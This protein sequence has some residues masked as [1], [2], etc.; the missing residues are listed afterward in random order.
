MRV[1]WKA[2]ASLST[3]STAERT[4]SDSWVSSWVSATATEVVTSATK[5]EAGVTVHAASSTATASATRF[6]SS[7]PRELADDVADAYRRRHRLQ[8]V[9]LHE[10]ARG[11]RPRGDD[12][13]RGGEMVARAHRE[14]LRL[15][16][17]P[18]DPRPHVRSRARRHVLRG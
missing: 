3:P 14:V 1:G 9:L 4:A 6:M 12:A 13:A 11:A 15:P 5:A 17:H 2:I 16:G 10:P 8:R 7:P 18:A